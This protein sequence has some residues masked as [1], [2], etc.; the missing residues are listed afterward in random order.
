MNLGNIYE[1]DD[2]KPEEQSEELLTIGIDN[3]EQEADQVD[4]DI[5]QPQSRRWTQ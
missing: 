5:G 4:D 2:G 1:W 3:E